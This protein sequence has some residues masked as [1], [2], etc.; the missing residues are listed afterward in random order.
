M[1]HLSCSTSVDAI[2]T[3]RPGPG[4]AAALATE[5]LAELDGPA[6]FLESASGMG[7]AAGLVLELCVGG[8]LAVAAGAR[9]GL[10]G[11][12]QR[13]PHALAARIGN[14]IPALDE[15]NRR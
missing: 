9:P 11:R 2:G 5:A 12:H 6:D 4:T 14:D 13:G 7:A 8:E 15:G 10:G 1:K 3:I